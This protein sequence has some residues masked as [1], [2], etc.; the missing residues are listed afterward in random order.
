MVSKDFN[1]LFE[2]FS[3]FPMSKVALTILRNFGGAELSLVPLILRLKS[4]N[5]KITNIAVK[6]QEN[7]SM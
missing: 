1:S 6:T 4:T 5:A 7:I 3:A 2:P